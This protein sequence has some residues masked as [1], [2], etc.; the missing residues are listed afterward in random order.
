MTG[1]PPHA[2]SPSVALATFAATLRFEQIPAPVVR[3]AEELLLD[4]VGSALAGRNARPVQSIARFAAT[5][6][7]ALERGRGTSEVLISRAAT[8][9]MWA[10]CSRAR[11]RRSRGPSRKRA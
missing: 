1:V 5:M 6:G 4:W 9:P 10:G 11:C 7:P 8:T 3:R 2:T